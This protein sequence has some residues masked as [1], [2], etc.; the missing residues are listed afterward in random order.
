[1]QQE[2]IHQKLLR[3]LRDC[4]VPLYQVAKESG[5]AQ[6]T[7]SRIFRGECIPRI[8]TAE[9]LLNWFEARQ[10]PKESAPVPA[11]KSANWE[12]VRSRA[13]KAAQVEP[14]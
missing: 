7:I 1:M 9:A 8:D 12:S 3:L 11:K 5:I 4:D 13:I 2:T 6:A 14:Q 10:A